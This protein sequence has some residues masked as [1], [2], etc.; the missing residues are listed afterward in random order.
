MV[1]R[2]KADGVLTIEQ[3]RDSAAVR[4]LLSRAGMID[5][6]LESS[7]SCYIMAYDGSP[8]VGVIGVETKVTVALVRSLLVLVQFRHRGIATELFAA[9]RKAAH[10]RGARELY[11]LSTEA[12]SF[13]KRMGFAE[14]PVAD[15]LLRLDGVPLVEYYQAR[16]DELAREVAW[17]LDISRDGLIDR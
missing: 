17:R 14:V 11:L 15:L 4:S 13:W 6:G 7:A 9:A 8:A 5:Y 12:P 10:T 3:T 16:P 1:L 2:K